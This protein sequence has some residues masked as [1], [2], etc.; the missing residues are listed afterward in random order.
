MEIQVFILFSHCCII[1][2]WSVFEKV[3]AAAVAA[4][5]CN[6]FHT[7]AVCYCT[8]IVHYCYC[9]LKR[10]SLL[11][12][13]DRKNRPLALQA[14]LLNNAVGPTSASVRLKLNYTKAIEK[15]DKNKRAIKNKLFEWQGLKNI[16]SAQRSKFL[17]V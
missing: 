1:N 12:A 8:L 14:P 6:C 7:N 2:C 13:V 10:C 3:F 5:Y 11:L 17:N 16:T 15:N 9:S 4:R